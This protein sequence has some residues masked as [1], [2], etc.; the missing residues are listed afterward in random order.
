MTGRRETSM[1]IVKRLAADDGGSAC[2][3]ESN[4]MDDT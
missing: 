3:H 4:V 1:S 2:S